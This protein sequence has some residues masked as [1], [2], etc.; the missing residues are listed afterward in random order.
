MIRKE[1][2]VTNPF[3]GFDWSENPLSKEEFA[4][5]MSA[6]KKWNTI[7]SELSESGPWRDDFIQCIK[8]QRKQ[9][10]FAQNEDLNFEISEFSCLLPN[11]GPYGPVEVSASLS[12]NGNE[13]SGLD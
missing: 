2:I 5:I 1:R 4:L 13:N 10:M 3:S 12:C 6:H 7:E 8:I 9:L 11:S